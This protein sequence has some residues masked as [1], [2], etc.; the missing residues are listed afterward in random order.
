MGEGVQVGKGAKTEEA[1]YSSIIEHFVRESSSF[2]PSI[3]ELKEL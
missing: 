1:N 2:S 3:I